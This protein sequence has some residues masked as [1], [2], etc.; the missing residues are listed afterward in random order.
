MKKLAHP[1][2]GAAVS[3][4]LLIFAGFVQLYGGS[5]PL[6]LPV[7][8]WIAALVPIGIGLI[9]TEKTPKRKRRQDSLKTEKTPNG[10]D[11]RTR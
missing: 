10:K 7:P 6:E 3:L 1:I 11:A 8:V 4:L 2:T 5:K 9:K